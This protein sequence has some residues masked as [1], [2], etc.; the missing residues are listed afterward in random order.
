VPRQQV[1]ASDVEA[2]LDDFDV[3]LTLG[4]EADTRMADQRC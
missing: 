1:S 4:E 2:E 3:E